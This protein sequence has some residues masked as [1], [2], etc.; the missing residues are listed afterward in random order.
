MISGSMI[1]A[2]VPAAY[3]YNVA[4]W[5]NSTLHSSTSVD[6]ST[7]SDEN[8]S[9]L[10]TYFVD[11]SEFYPLIDQASSSVTMRLEDSLFAKRSKLY[12]LLSDL[13]NEDDSSVLSFF[14]DIRSETEESQS[15]DQIMR[16][17]LGAYK[18]HDVAL[19]V[20]TLRFMRNFTYQEIGQF[21]IQ[22]AA[23]SLVVQWKSND[24]K[25]VMDS[26]QVPN[27]VFIR[28]KIRKLPEWYI[29]ER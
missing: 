25:A 9:R 3:V 22:S 6:S 19:V 13:Q 4:S 10:T 18:K 14:E 27:D 17:F 5:G 16:I 11:F 12:S 20:K 7:A 23:I 29:S 26:Y 28:A 24:F 1:S 8:T 21:D 2:S 15:F